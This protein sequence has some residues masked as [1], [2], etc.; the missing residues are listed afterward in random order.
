ME[1]LSNLQAPVRQ[2]LLVVHFLA[3]LPVLSLGRAGRRTLPPSRSHINEILHQGAALFARA[4][5]EG[6]SHA[7]SLS[8]P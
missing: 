5:H 8:P 1:L 4:A 6:A 7:T 3:D 2:Q